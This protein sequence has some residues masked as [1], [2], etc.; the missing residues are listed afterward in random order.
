MFAPLVLALLATTPESRADAELELRATVP[1]VVTVDGRPSRWTSKLRHR[2]D[3]L[4][5]GTLDIRIE[6]LFGTVLYEGELTFEDNRTLHA[7]WRKGELE[8]LGTSP[9]GHDLVPGADGVELSQDGA[10]VAMGSDV[11]DDLGRLDAPGDPIDL[12]I[13]GVDAA[14]ADE[15]TE[16]PLA[17]P[18]GAASPGAPGTASPPDHTMATMGPPPAAPPVA[19]APPV[20]AD[21]TPAPPGPAARSAEIRLSDGMSLEVLYGDRRLILVREEGSLVLDDGQGFRLELR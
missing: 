16:R 2:V 11:Q 18:A 1:V 12:G 17:I 7:S 8:V 21:P 4:E 15:P 6:S 13:R 3:R 19:E 14:P 20:V 9:L 10:T 5:P